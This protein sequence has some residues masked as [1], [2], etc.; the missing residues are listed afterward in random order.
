VGAARLLAKEHGVLGASHVRDKLVEMAHLTETIHGLGLGASAKSTR[1]ACGVWQVDPVLAN[2]CKHNVTRLPYEVVRLAEDLAGGL[3]GTMPSLADLEHP[4][5]GAALR[6]VVGSDA[7]ARTLRLVEW[8]SYGAG[9]VPLRLECMHGAGSPQAQ[10]IVLERAI[11]WEQ[12]V[13]AARRLAGLPAG[14]GE[15]GEDRRVDAEIEAA[16]G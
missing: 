10:R 14:A 7:R 2:V 4:E 15:A 9:S 3:L 12:K 6:G 16:G 13:T 11:D 5:L 8:M 1:H